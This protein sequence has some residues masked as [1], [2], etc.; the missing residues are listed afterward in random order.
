LEMIL[1]TDNDLNRRFSLES[2]RLR[3]PIAAGKL[4]ADRFL[5]EQIVNHVERN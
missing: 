5:G 3:F 2:R 4:S 1:E